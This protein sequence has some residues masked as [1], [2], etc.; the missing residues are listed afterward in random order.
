MVEMS[1]EME[2][3]SPS[4]PGRKGRVALEEL[5]VQIEQ[6]ENERDLARHSAEAEQAKNLALEQE[7]YELRAMVEEVEK[8]AGRAENKILRES[9]QNEKELRLATESDVARQRHTL[10]DTNS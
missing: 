8:P 6:L 4:P 9:L 10:S 5:M 3:G 1:F 7:F 2:A